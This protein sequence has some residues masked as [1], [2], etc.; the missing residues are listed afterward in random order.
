MAQS[1]QVSSQISRQTA[2]QM[3]ESGYAGSRTPSNIIYVL[4]AASHVARTQRNTLLGAATGCAAIFSSS[5]SSSEEIA[6][7]GCE[8]LPHTPV[9]Q[10][11]RIWRNVSAVNL[12]C[13]LLTISDSFVLHNTKKVSA[14]FQTAAS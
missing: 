8:K 12:K 14:I 7:A 10:S 13:R 1:T 3:T 4:Y 2:E 9:E 11:Q 5:W 6:H